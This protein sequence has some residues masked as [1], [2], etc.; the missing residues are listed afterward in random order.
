VSFVISSVRRQLIAAFVAV[1]LMFTISLVIGWTS[2]GS[3]NDKVQSSAQQD[4]VLVAATG[5]ARNMVA[6]QAIAV[7]DPTTLSDHEGDV[8]LFRQTVRRLSAYIT[9]PAAQAAMAQLNR[10]FS[11][12]A[13]LDTGIDADVRAHARSTATKLVR[14]PASVAADQVT[15]DVAALSRAI[16]NAT[17]QAAASKAS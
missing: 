16:S 3:I 2:V 1:S 5:N 7:L 11:T 15:S 6:S 12:W 14:G 8:Q 17:A 13:T 9:T 10:A 4:G